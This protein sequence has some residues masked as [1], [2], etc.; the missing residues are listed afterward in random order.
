MTKKALGK[1]LGAIIQHPVE[2]TEQVVNIPVDKI[3]VNVY[4]PRRK[5]DNERFK[6]LVDSVREKGILNPV[7]VRKAGS[8]YELIAGERRYRAAKTL[9]MDKIL[10]IVKT[11]N[12][13]ESLE[14]AL[15]EN[16]Q[17]EDLNP[18]EEAEG[19][20][21]LMDNFGLTQQLV[22]QRVGKNRTTVANILR[23][24]FLPTKVKSYIEKGELSFGHAK[25]LLGVKS[26]QKQIEVCQKIVKTG[27][28]VR[29]LEKLLLLVSK[30]RPAK[31]KGRK[32]FSQVKKIEDQLQHVL[33]TK[34]TLKNRG[35]KGKIEIE[36]YSLDDLDRI[37]EYFKIEK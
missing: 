23:I 9:E 25:V 24:L 30:K 36:Y 13:E 26:S 37:L 28:S 17:R 2:A 19:Y 18:I 10:A 14:L 27:I 22:A 15:I 3:K 1:G 34:V 32:R 8:G 16:L 7:I 12:N 29:E 35:S 5:F 20:K 6:E 31:Q 33:G 21:S 4:Q 11:A